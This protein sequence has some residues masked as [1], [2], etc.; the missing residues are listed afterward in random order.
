M[1]KYER[2]IYLKKSGSNW[3]VHKIIKVIPIY[4]FDDG[5]YELLLMTDDGII[6]RIY[7]KY[8]EDMQKK[9]FKK[10]YKYTSVNV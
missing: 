5:S 8:L 2:M 1:A 4:Q 9:N 3:T 6:L 10:K 7:S